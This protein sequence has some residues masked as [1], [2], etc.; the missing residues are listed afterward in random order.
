[1][2]FKALIEIPAGSNVKYEQDEE[3]G[4]L[5]VDRFL[6][7]AFS[8]PFN[9]GYIKGTKA[10]DG[11][12]LDVIV[13]SSQSVVPGV[14]IKCHAIGILDME[15]E[16]G[17]DFK[18]IAVPDK[19]VDPVYGEYQDIQ[20]VPQPILNKIKHFFENYKTLE[21]GK[22]VKVKE[23]GG[24]EKAEKAIATSKEAS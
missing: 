19:K 6:Y 10:E 23:F 7:T 20:S 12:P 15:D 11:D 4:E 24:R 5:V 13:L 2:D 8:Y 17:Q 1:M 3:T 21:P 14:V 16:E 22:W 9:Y 18:I